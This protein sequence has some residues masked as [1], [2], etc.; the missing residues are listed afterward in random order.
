MADRSRIWLDD[1][2]WWLGIAEFKPYNRK[3]GTYLN[4]GLMF[5][6]HPSSRYLFEVGGTL[7]ARA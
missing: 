1:Q 3:P 2:S 6:W 4:P 5:L 7:P